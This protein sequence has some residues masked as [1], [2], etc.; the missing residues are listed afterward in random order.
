MSHPCPEERK[1]KVGIAMVRLAA[2]L[3]MA[4]ALL[5]LLLWT[6]GA[7]G[8]ELAVAGQEPLA[9]ADTPTTVSS[10]LVTQTEQRDPLPAT[11]YLRYTIHLENASSTPL[12]SIS[13][14]DT[15]P[16]GTYFV[17]TDMGGV[18]AERVIT[19]TLPSLAWG[20]P[21]DLHVEL[22]TASWLRGTISNTVT[23]GIAGEELIT[24]TETTTFLSPNAI[25]TA[26][27]GSPPL[28]APTATPQATPTLGPTSDPLHPP[29]ATAPFVIPVR[30]TPSTA[31]PADLPPVIFVMLDWTNGDWGNPDYS[32]SYL[33]S[34]GAQVELRGHPEYGA[35]GGWNEFPWDELNPDAGVYD[36]GKVDRYIRDAQ[37]MKVT[38]PDGTVIAKPIGISVVTWTAHED[39]DKIGIN[40]TPK[41]IAERYGAEISDCYDPDGAA[42]GCKPYCTPNFTD[43]AWQYWFDQFILAM[44]RHYDNNPAFYNLAWINIA[45]G[46]DAETRQRKNTQGCMYYAGN[47]LFFDRWCAHVLETYNRAFPHLPQ[48]IQTSS[49]GI[50]QYASM[51]AAFPS[52]MTGVKVNG[53]AVDHRNAEIYFDDVLV[54]GVTGTSLLFHKWIPTG[55]EPGIDPGTFGVYW[56]LMEGLSAHPHLVDIQLPILE[57]AYQA[58]RQTGFPLLNFLR[59][60]LDRT[61]ADTPDVWIVLRETQQTSSCWN[62]GI[63]IYKCYSPHRGDY[64]YWLYRRED[65]PASRT[66]ALLGGAL[67][68]ELPAEA[69]G[70]IYSYHSSRRTDQ[71]SGNRYMSFDVD[72]DYTFAGATPR[73]AGGSVEWTLIVTVLNQG[74]DTLS[75]E[76][77]NANGDWIE[78]RIRKGPELGPVDT[79]VDYTW[80][81]DD[82]YFAD[83]LPGGVDFRLDCNDDGDEFIHRL[84]V[85]GE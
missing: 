77:Q 34:S 27:P 68:R 44:G 81:V 2:L 66:V 9:T 47:S 42:G 62:S 38:L 5:G 73:A 1:S 19:W 56:M 18:Y 30:P 3:A 78:R 53:L 48:F 40:R 24:D 54:G 74:T 50:H 72:D 60:H 82:A 21:V 55:F 58:E 46:V 7:A 71:A 65:A 83:S 28:P 85:R 16:R 23:V 10:L 64:E 6:F 43:P 70:H 49:E 36:W 61:P 31:S 76:Y 26:T 51:A 14:T 17:T 20:F 80:Q 35:L 32:F 52:Q 79:W 69:R 67:A 84:I 12:Y 11:W 41:W 15:L 29:T 63:G 75:L 57:N 22:A 45:T 59:V 13:I 4:I 37:R 39:L 25:P 8:R 33:S